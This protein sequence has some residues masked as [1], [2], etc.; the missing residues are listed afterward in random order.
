MKKDLIS[1]SAAKSPLGGMTS[2]RWE[3][4]GFFAGNTVVSIFLKTRKIV[5]SR[6]DSP[7]NDH[8]N[9]FKLTFSPE[10]WNSFVLPNLRRSNFLAWE[11]EYENL[12]VLDGM[13]WRLTVRYGRKWR[14]QSC[15]SNAFPK[16]AKIFCTFL[17]EC[18]ELKG[19]NADGKFRSED[20]PPGNLGRR[21]GQLFH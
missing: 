15:G 3:A 1:Q 5:L 9:D 10:Y 14:F 8:R 4:G 17:D 7:F 12:N 16:E 18:F 2:I 19:R 13:S 6:S 21:G 11:P 20:L